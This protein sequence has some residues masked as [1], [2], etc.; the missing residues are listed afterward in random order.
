MELVSDWGSYHMVERH[1]CRSVSLHGH[2]SVPEAS[3]SCLLS[4][5]GREGLQPSVLGPQMGLV[6]KGSGKHCWSP[7]LMNTGYHCMEHI[8]PRSWKYKYALHKTLWLQVSASA[9]A[10]NNPWSLPFCRNFTRS[11]KVTVKMSRTCG[12]RW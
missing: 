3:A 5:S 11:L 12:D 6:V 7:G 8:Y 4:A 10:G 1:S 2:Y 9:A